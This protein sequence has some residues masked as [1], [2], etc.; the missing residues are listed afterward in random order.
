MVELRALDAETPLLVDVSLHVD[1]V[2]RLGHV[3]RHEVV[4]H[5]HI[6]Q[7]HFPVQLLVGALGLDHVFNFVRLA[8]LDGDAETS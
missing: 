5:G 4:H 2:Q 6:H 7:E 3:G 1:L 8:A